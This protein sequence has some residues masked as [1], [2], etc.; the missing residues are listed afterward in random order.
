MKALITK[1]NVGAV[2]GQ[3]N[4]S[5]NQNSLTH[6]DPWCWP[7]DHDTPRKETVGVAEKSSGERKPCQHRTLGSVSGCSPFLGEERDR[8]LVCG[9]CIARWSGI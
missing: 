6:R 2:N 3:G 8:G 1:N 7:A 9:Q 5:S 4:Q